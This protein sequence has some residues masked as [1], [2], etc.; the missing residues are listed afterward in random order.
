MNNEEKDKQILRD[1][2]ESLKSSKKD[3]KEMITF[4]KVTE[5]SKKL[6]NNEKVEDVEIDEYVGPSE[7]SSVLAGKAIER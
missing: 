3:H 1:Y 5:I 2:M 6:A 7:E 4:E